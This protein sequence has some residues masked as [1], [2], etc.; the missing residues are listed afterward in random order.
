MRRDRLLDPPAGGDDQLPHG[1]IVGGQPLDPGKTTQ[2]LE[3]VGPEGVAHAVDRDGR[4][5]FQQRQVG[6]HTLV[7]DEL[8][9]QV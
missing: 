8:G 1:E 2:R 9:D 5:K 7:V 3:S 6:E 4:K